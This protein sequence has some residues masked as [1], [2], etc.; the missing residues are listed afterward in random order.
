L[1]DESGLEGGKDLLDTAVFGERVSQFLKT[2]VGQ[3]LIDRADDER[4]AAVEAIKIVNPAS[5]NDV[6]RLQNR[7]WLMEQFKTWLADAVVAGLQAE[8]ALQGE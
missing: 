8:K 4:D 1:A 5:I 3:Y 2:D 6:M 7:I